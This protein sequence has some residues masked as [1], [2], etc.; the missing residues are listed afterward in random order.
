[1]SINFPR[2]SNLSAHADGPDNR[3]KW[4]REP[5]LHKL[6]YRK[7]IHNDILHECNLKHIAIWLNRYN[8]LFFWDH[9]LIEYNQIRLINSKVKDT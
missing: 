9:K 4:A 5:K 6:C 7:S 2:I 1:M 8:S 3:I